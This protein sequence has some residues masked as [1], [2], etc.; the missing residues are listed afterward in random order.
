MRITF[1]V[2]KRE[3]SERRFY[4]SKTL[5]VTTD[6]VYV[7]RFRLR[8]YGGLTMSFATKS[9]KKELPFISR[10]LSIF[11]IVEERQMRILFS[12]LSPKNYGKIITLMHREGLVYFTPDGKYI[13]SNETQAR[14][15]D[16][17]SCVLC[18]WAFIKIRDMMQDFCAGEEP[19]LV[20]VASY[21]RDYDLI[22]ITEDN[23]KLINDSI[24]EIPEH[25]VR[26]LITDD[27]QKIV[28]IDR[29]MK[30]DYLLHINENGEIETYEM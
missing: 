9:R 2:F 24:D 14:R 1:N 27:L 13:A 23:L 10:L 6:F 26:Y 8:T 18:F 11:G 29:R 3:R 30:N 22:P 19:A 12:H 7:Q 15:S 20:T 21:E 5:Y 17:K 25:S 16:R 28:G 4:I